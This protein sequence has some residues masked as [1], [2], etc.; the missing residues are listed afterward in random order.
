LAYDAANL[1]FDGISRAGSTD[2]TAIRDALKVSDFKAVSGTIKFD[3]NR[4][5]IKAA[6]IIEIKGGVQTYKATVQP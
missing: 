4:N 1:M 3:A 2:G 5:P 6:V